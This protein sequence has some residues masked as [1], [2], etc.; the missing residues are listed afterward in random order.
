MFQAHCGNRLIGQYQSVDEAAAAYWR[1]KMVNIRD[2]AVRYWNHLPEAL[3]MRL[4]SFDWPDASAYFP[5]EFAD[6]A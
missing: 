2:L 4:V 5:E 1:A 6:D 3:A